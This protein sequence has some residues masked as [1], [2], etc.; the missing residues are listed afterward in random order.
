MPTPSVTLSDENTER[1]SKFV[2]TVQK[3]SKAKDEE[4]LNLLDILIHELI[5]SEVSSQSLVETLVHTLL[6]LGVLEEP[7]YYA[8]VF[9]HFG[10]FSNSWCDVLDPTTLFVVNAVRCKATVEQW[11]DANGYF[12]AV[13]ISFL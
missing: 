10:G 12:F 2:K 3:L 1:L 5:A 6:Q 11:F 8:L 7:A 9:S 13:L 4:S